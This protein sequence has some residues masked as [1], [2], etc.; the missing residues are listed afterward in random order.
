MPEVVALSGH[1]DFTPGRTVAIAKSA[2]GGAHCSLADVLETESE[3][4]DCEGFR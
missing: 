1:G 3:A 2:A 4:N